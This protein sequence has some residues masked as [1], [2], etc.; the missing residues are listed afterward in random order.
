MNMHVSH[1]CDQEIFHPGTAQYLL[2]DRSGSWQLLTAAHWA[3]CGPDS[4]TARPVITPSHHPMG[5][6]AEAGRATDPQLLFP[7]QS[8][9][10][11][12]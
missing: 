11:L 4:C 3:H 8:A 7:G 12:F 10:K 1:T 6:T 9:P 2:L 5:S